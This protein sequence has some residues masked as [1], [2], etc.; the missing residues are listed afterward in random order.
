VAGPAP[1]R[2]DQVDALRAIAMTA[3]IVEHCGLMHFG[4]MGVWLFFVISGFVVTGSLLKD[5]GR[6]PG[7][8]VLWKFARVNRML[9]G[10][11]PGQA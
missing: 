7:G 11:A 4:W 3:V 1:G 5:R 6:A 8:T 9:R 2:L 10:G